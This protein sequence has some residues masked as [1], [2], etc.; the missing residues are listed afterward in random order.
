MAR[1]QPGRAPTCFFAGNI[2]VALIVC[3]YAYCVAF[4]Q[5]TRRLWEVRNNY[6]DTLTAFHVVAR[7]NSR[8]WRQPV[9]SEVSWFPL[10]FLPAPL[11]SESIANRRVVNEVRFLNNKIFTF[12]LFGEGAVLIGTLHEMTL[13]S[14]TWQHRASLPCR[15]TL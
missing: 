4:F 3:R 11:S 7:R 8:Q 15:S 14:S 10:F 2:N 1:R 9:T 5:I 13:Y 6:G 12:I